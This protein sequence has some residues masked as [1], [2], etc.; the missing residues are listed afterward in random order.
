M[1]QVDWTSWP[2]GRTQRSQ[3]QKTALPCLLCVVGEEKAGLRYLA[4]LLAPLYRSISIKH[5][6]ARRS[7]PAASPAFSLQPEARA[8]LIVG[9]DI[10]STRPTHEAH[11]LRP[12]LRQKI[13]I[14]PAIPG[15]FF[16]EL[17]C[18]LFVP[19]GTS[20]PS[21]LAGTGGMAVQGRF[22]PANFARTKVNCVIFSRKD[23]GST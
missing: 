10:S 8:L 7:C 9:F 5:L 13:K 2:R 17:A 20:H 14:T 4:L 16:R 6:A 12:P 22:A 21:F 23:G 3:K 1:S 15:N 19:R 11:G 18:I